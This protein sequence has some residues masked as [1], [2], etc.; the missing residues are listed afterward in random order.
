MPCLFLHAAL[1]LH[2]KKSHNRTENSLIKALDVERKH[3]K[4][5]LATSNVFL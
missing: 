2:T 5:S 3:V 1:R 4:I